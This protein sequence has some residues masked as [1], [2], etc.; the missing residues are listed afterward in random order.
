MTAFRIIDGTDACAYCGEIADTEDHIV[1]QTN[2]DR[3]HSPLQPDRRP[4]RPS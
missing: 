4:R 2:A 1:P 3:V